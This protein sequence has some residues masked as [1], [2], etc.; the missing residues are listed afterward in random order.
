MGP[1]NP[2][3]DGGHDVLIQTGWVLAAVDKRIGCGE[4]SHR[5]HGRCKPGKTRN[6]RH[7]AVRRRGAVA[8]AQGNAASR[9]T[10]DASR[11]V[12]VTNPPLPRDN[13]RDGERDQQ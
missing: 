6:R 3:A 13:K 10:Q 7:T 11:R 8:S 1:R 12:G 2:S 4:G 9:Q 5:V